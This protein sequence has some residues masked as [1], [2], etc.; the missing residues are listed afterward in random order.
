MNFGNFIPEDKID[1]IFDKFYRADSYISATCQGSGLGLYIVK[2]LLDKM[3]GKIEVKSDLIKNKE[4]IG[5]MDDFIKED[6]AKTEFLIY[7]P[8]Y[9][10]EKITKKLG[11][12]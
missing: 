8:V 4:N 1:K 3:Q 11:V 6:I 7:F 5:K 12:R 9:E 10:V 2:T